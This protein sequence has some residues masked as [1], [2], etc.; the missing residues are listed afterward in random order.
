MDIYLCN[1]CRYHLAENIQKIGNIHIV[2][3]RKSTNAWI[4]SR[5]STIELVPSPTKIILNIVYMGEGG[6][7]ISVPVHV[8]MHKQHEHEWNMYMGMNMDVDM[9]KDTDM[10]MDTDT[11]MGIN[12]NMDMDTDI[13]LDLDIRKCK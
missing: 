13:K 2:A 8:H 4:S 6:A 1:Y 3:N 5:V 9:D 12:M 7:S 10:D 11:D